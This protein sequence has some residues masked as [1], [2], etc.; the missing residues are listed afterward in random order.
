LNDIKRTIANEETFMT[1]TRI[2]FSYPKELKDQLE[3]LANEDNRSLSSFIQI[4][5]KEGIEKRMNPED[6][7]KD[8]NTPKPDLN[9]MSRILCKAISKKLIGDEKFQAELMDMME[10]DIGNDN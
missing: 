9:S 4:L 10:D 6:R 7:K 3:K 1:V 5:L 8:L 2:S